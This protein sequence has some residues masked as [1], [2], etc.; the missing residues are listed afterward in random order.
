MEI[1]LFGPWNKVSRLLNQLP[2]ELKD[3]SISSQRSVAEKFVRKI[4]NHLSNQDIPGWTPLSNSYADRKMG[5]F[6][7]EEILIASWQYYESIKTWRENNS[8]HA[9][10][11][12]GVSYEN[13][14]EIAAVAKI[15]EDWS[16]IPGK[17]HR[18]L[19]NF[20][21]NEDMGGLKGIKKTVNEIIITRLIK[22]GYPINSLKL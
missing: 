22:K 9:G 12:K 10:V 15:H 2:R 13:G 20:T 16:M 7:H 18:P 17:P 5:K 4:K 21:I 1:K 6:G 3:I 11:P 19:W 8:Y 14:T